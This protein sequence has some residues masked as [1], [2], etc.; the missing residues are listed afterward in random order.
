MG[1]IDCDTH[2][3]EYDHTWS[4]LS[5]TEQQYRPTTWQSKND[6]GHVRKQFIGRSGWTMT[7]GDSPLGSGA[8]RDEELQLYPLGT[9]TLQDTKTR[10]RQMDDWGVDVQ[11]CHPT[12]WGIVTI[13]DPAEELALTNSYNR[14][15][16]DAT[17]STNGRLRWQIQPAMGSPEAVAAQLEWGKAHGAVGIHLQGYAHFK[18]LTDPSFYPV[19][20]KAEELG[21]VC[22]VH[23]GQGDASRNPKPASPTG[24]IWNVAA[25]VVGAFFHLLASDFHTRFPGLKWLFVEAGGMWAPWMYQQYSRAGADLWRDLDSDWTKGSKTI[26]AERNIWVSAEQDDDLPYLLKHMGDDHFTLGSDYGHMDMGTDPYIHRQVLEREDIPLESRSKIADSNARTLFGIDPA[27]TP[28]DD[29]L[30]TT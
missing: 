15:M 8:H 3:W 10:M 17:S 28:A 18:V 14:W 19:W 23:V 1:Y 30:V 20:E 12:G 24:V 26:L 4:Y 5:S 25:P 21:L 7:H 22:L 9:R 27:F 6:F 13:N 16:A 29:A 11:I 2:I